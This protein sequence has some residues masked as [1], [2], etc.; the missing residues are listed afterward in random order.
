LIL[1]LA[2]PPLALAGSSAYAQ[3]VASDV[4]AGIQF[5]KDLGRTDPS[6]EINITVH[7]KLSDKAAF[8]AAV[9]ALYDPASPNFHQWMTNDDL[10][11]FAPS[12][13]QRSSVRAELAAHGLTILSTDILGFMIRARGTIANVESAFKTEIHQFEHNGIV[14]RANVRDIQLTGEAGNYVSS[15]AGIEG[16]QMRPLAVRA[17][18][19]RTHQ[20]FPSVKVDTL[21]KNSGFPAG[22]TPDGLSAPETLMLEGTNGANAV[23]TGTVY[24]ID[25]NLIPDYLP[26]QL[27][28]VLGLNEVYAA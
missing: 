12:E 18:D 27:Q 14:Y 22:S 26:S 11:K 10:K 20:P 16:H 17:V 7:L 23:Y 15:V 3:E 2:I 19:L 8:D 5:S 24:D 28:T 1:A 4:P 6:T 25:P 9:D 13:A 21:P